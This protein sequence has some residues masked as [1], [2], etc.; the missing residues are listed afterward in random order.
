MEML[1]F[2][3][4]NRLL[5]MWWEQEDCAGEEIPKFVKEAAHPSCLTAVITQLS[6]CMSRWE[7]FV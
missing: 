6:L 7:I 3:S 1:L 5:Q 2:T 4:V